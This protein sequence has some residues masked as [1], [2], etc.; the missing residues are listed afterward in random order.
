MIGRPS[1][2]RAIEVAAKQFGRGPG[3]QT[4]HRMARNVRSVLIDAAN[5]VRHIHM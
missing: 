1:L 2:Q 5:G 4:H 3:D